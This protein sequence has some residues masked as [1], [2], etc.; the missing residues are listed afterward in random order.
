MVY[1]VVDESVSSEFQGVGIEYHLILAGRREESVSGE[2][3]CRAP[4][5]N[6]DE[7]AALECEHLVVVFLPEFLNGFGLEVVLLVHYADHGIVEAVEVF[8]F[9]VFAVN[10]VPLASGI[11]IAPSVAFTREVDPFR[12][13][14]LIAHEVEVAAVDAGERHEAYHLVESHAA[15]HC[16]VVVAVHH[17]P[18][19]LLVDESEYYGLVAYEGL[20]VAL[21]VGDCLLVGAAVGEFPEDGGRVPVFVFLL[22][23]HL[24]PV[25]GDAHGHAVVEADAAVFELYGEAGHAA[26]LLGD[27]DSVGVHFM[28]EE[29]G[30]RKVYNG[31]GVLVAVVIVRIS[32]ECFSEA[33]VIIEHGRDAVKPESVKSVFIL[34]ELAVAEKEIEHGVLAVVEEQGV[35]CR[36]LAAVALVEVKVVAS[37]ESAESFHFVFHGVAVYYVHDHCYSELV[38]V[39]DQT[40]QVVGR[41]K[42]ARRRIEAADVVAK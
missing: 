34:P 14:E 23:D 19:H 26:H 16:E 27:G 42:A 20:V 1:A 29:V 41:S 35:P 18:V 8:V 32:A 17:V 33:M 31:V 28:Y 30:E 11:L 22:L 10:E 7:V 37:V 21:A 39:V 25:V 40:L 13:S 38:G 2:G 9:Q 15:L 12:M 4:V 3:L 5:E 36:M 6:E 24:D